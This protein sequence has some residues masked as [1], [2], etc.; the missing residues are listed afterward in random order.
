ML[1][2]NGMHNLEAVQKFRS[3]S[4]A[5]VNM[6]TYVASINVGDRILLGCAAGR[7]NEGHGAQAK[8]DHR[9]GGKDL[10][11]DFECERQVFGQGTHKNTD[12]TGGRQLVHDQ[13]SICFRLR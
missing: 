11:S 3:S 2:F 10:L 9:G 8:G 7:G 4:Q 13:E 6:V 1:E 5:P 12:N